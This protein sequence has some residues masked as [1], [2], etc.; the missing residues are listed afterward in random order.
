M[1]ESSLSPQPAAPAV[2]QSTLP[3]TVQKPATFIERFR[4]VLGC[5]L[6]SLPGIALFL[7]IREHRV[8]IPFLDDW[9]FVHMFEKD[10]LGTLTV[11]DYFM[12]QMEHRMA[13]VRA[14]IMVFHK[15][16]PT[17]WTM[18]MFFCWFLLVLTQVN[19][20]VLI[21]RTSGKSFLTWW[22]LLMLAA[23]TLFS[24]VQYRIV[25]WAMM[26]QVACPA[27][28]LSTALVAVTSPWPLWLRW[29]VGVLAASCATQSFASG[30]LVWL[31]PL[32]IVWFG[33]VIR[34]SLARHIFGALWL[35]AF[36]ITMVLYFHDLKNEV[37]S[38]FA[39]KQQDG[40]ETL[41]SDL[42][43]FLKEPGRA[44]PYVLRFLGGH[45][46]RGSS[47]SVMHASFYAGLISVLLY[48]GAMAYL[49]WH[50]KRLDIR[51][52]LLPW[53]MF[54]AYSIATACLV[55]VGRMWAS[56]NGDNAIAPRYAIH[57]V[58]LTVS[59]I[60][61][62]WLIV[63][64]WQKQ[65][66]TP[67]R[68]VNRAML[69]MAVVLCCV[70]AA[71]WVHGQH[72]ME[73]WQSSRLRGAVTTRFVKVMP[74]M[75]NVVPV[76]PH[77][78]ILADRLGL[79]DPP[80][81]KDRQLNNFRL[82]PKMLSSNTARFKN[83]EIG[84]DDDGFYGIA[85]GYACLA[86][87]ERVADG[88]FLTRRIPREGRWEIFHVEQVT[89]MPLFLGE[90]FFKDTQFVHLPG[91]S[92]TQEVLAGFSGRF[93][94]N[95]LPPGLHDIMAWAYDSKKNTVFPIA[96]FFEL[97]TRGAHPKLKRL[98]TNPA[99]VHLSK[100]LEGG[101]NPQPQSQPATEE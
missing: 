96:G 52:K 98:G 61:L 57:P 73:M 17:D 37:D 65:R 40:H 87:R 7:L 97:D 89:G 43:G 8:N 77:Y 93:R 59:L 101:K 79:L 49:L 19:V 76:N 83:I 63:R 67:V 62:T 86:S 2:S 60:V 22:P 69:A 41:K 12:V 75:D 56:T 21:K 78:A 51:A 1:V 26:F 70:Q 44:V 29:I 34:N 94:L 31:L 91:Q 88:V 20:G 30:I 14:V 81:L 39:Y 92:V 5:L 35:V 3:G 55:A 9:M 25:L 4:L 58:P 53:L 47:L 33:G 32:P 38:A 42:A 6:V 27:F 18:Q 66:E 50:W 71:S 85:E 54:G 90:M 11:A 68:T 10:A 80:L 28:F 36:G 23:L 100:F 13:F 48:T 95:E 46:G 45:L 72:L 82:A 64:D 15:V 74:E 24:P 16:W 84:M 99:A